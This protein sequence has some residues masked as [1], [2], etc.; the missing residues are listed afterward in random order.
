MTI[1]TVLVARLAAWAAGVP[2]GDDHIYLGPDQLGC[3]VRNAL[4]VIGGPPV[5]DGDI[6]SLDVTDFAK[7][8]AECF[9]GLRRQ[10]GRSRPEKPYT[11]KIGSWLLRLTRKRHG[12]DDNGD[13][14]HE[15]ASVVSRGQ[16]AARRRADPADPDE[17]LPP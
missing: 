1:G 14:G 9:D 12:E 10:L 2:L 3:E 8:S 13:H 17:A 6:L 11:G 5:L 16:R 7:A 4:E 15:G